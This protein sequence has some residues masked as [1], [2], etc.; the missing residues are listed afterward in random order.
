[1]AAHLCPPTAIGWKARATHP[2][3]L[4]RTTSAAEQAASALH[5]MAVLQVFQAKMLANEDAGL[6]SASLRDLRSAT[7]LALCATKA[8]AQAIGRSMSSLIMLERHLWRIKFPSSTLR[9]RQVACMDQLWRASLNVS[10]RLR[11]HLKQ[12]DTSSLNAPARGTL[13]G[14]KNVFSVPHWPAMAPRCPTAGIANKIKHKHFQKESKLPCLP[15]RS[16][17][18]LC[19]QSAQPFQRLAWQAIPGLSAWVTNTVRRG[20]SLQFARRPPRFRGVLVH[21][22]AQQRRSCPPCRGDESAGKRSH[23]NRSSNPERVRFYSRY[24]L[25]PK[26]DVSL[27]PILNLRLDF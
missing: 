22:S 5:S 4:C 1:M 18:P 9:S 12:C 3:K 27:R 2:S 26:K 19:S 21:L 15:P 6:D 23:R 17:L 11:S 14:K 13:G 25:V 20:Y 16:V 8:T 10:R 7:D 24:F